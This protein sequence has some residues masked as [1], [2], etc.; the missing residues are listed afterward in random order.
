MSYSYQAERAKLFTEDGQE[1]FIKVRDNVHELL[2]SAGAFQAGKAWQGVSGD[3]WKMLA[4]LDRLVEMG[5]IREVT[6]NT[7]GQHR[8]F[9]SGKYEGR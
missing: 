8:V 7:W 4:C 5:E 1:M 6:S 9:V 3:S 2:D